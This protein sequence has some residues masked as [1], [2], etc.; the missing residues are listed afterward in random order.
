MTTRPEIEPLLPTRLIRRRL[1]TVLGRADHG[2]TLPLF[3]GCFLIAGLLLTGGIAASAAFLAQRDVQSLCDGAAVA[4]ANVAD[5]SAIYGGGLSDGS[6]PL[7]PAS[8]QAAVADYLSGREIDAWQATTDGTTVR[9][10]CS[11]QVAI[12]FGSVFLLSGTLDR[13]A[14]A[15][16]RSPFAT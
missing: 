13:T 14:V 9:V 3:I 5:E 15:S 6:L 11:R 7:S 10:V 2:S 16:A 12:P 4:G 1:A 8:V